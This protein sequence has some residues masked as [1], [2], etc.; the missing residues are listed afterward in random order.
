ML[1]TIKVIFHKIV[2]LFKNIFKANENFVKD[3]NEVK[4]AFYTLIQEIKD[5]LNYTKEK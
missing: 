1:K 2:V 3:L 5:M 4:L